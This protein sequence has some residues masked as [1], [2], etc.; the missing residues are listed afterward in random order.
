MHVAI[1][2]LFISYFT[3]AY[4]LFQIGSYGVTAIDIITAVIYIIFF[5]RIIWDGDKIEFVPKMQLFFFFLLLLSIF[6]SGFSPLFETSTA[7]TGQYLKTTGHMI[8]LGFFAFICA[9]YNIKPVVWNSVIRTWLIIGLLIN[10]FG[11]YQIVARAYD[12]P[13][14][15]LEFT[16]VSITGRGMYEMDEFQQL[17]L[18]FGNFYRATSIFYEPSAL[19]A[20]NIYMLAFLI[21]P[22]MQKRE[23]FFKSKFVTTTM[24]LFAL[25]ATFLTFSLTGFLGI[26]LIVSSI[27][28]F[29]KGKRKY[30]LFGI[31]IL[32]GI[33]VFITDAI[34]QSYA[35]ISVLELFEKRLEGILNYGTAKATVVEG[36]SYATRLVSAEKTFEI[37]KNHPFTGIGL[38]LTEQN[39]SVL[40]SFS[41]FGV[42]A[43]LAEM[44]IFG[45]ISFTGIFASFLV[46]SV[47][48][49][50]NRDS[51][52]NLSMEKQRLIG[53]VYY[54]LLVLI[55]INFISSN[56]LVNGATWIPIG[57]L[58]S[59]VSRT[60]IDSGGKY[61]SIA[62]IDESLKDKSKKLLN[63]YMAHKQG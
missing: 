24:F 48:Y 43:A 8:F 16:N 54:I 49:L 26:F 57:I 23:A 51:Y 25:I 53:I 22:F 42:L 15:W 44:G 62:L 5:K 31:F 12:L 14:A 17:S 40:L 37:W 13:L 21:I 46:I 1:V 27:I 34:V 33:I 58:F 6:L 45:F 39:K 36:E 18:K 9:I 20:F 35:E 7:M 19:A 28:I 38:G 3:S 11:I 10:I 2:L 41:D 47:R 60:S 55:I 30:S 61:Y 59:V 29:E 56:N 50:L 4:Q 63:S 32:A 52:K